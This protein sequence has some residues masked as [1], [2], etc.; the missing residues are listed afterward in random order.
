MAVPHRLRVAFTG[1][2]KAMSASS[3]SQGA[4][5][6]PLSPDKRMLLHLRDTLYEGSWEE[7]VA[8]LRSRMTGNPYVFNTLP[9]TP[10]LRATIEEHLGLIERMR[11]WEQANRATLRPDG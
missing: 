1:E 4:T 7:L 6:F 8:D 2:L 5:V 9:E 10:S 3:E 11:S